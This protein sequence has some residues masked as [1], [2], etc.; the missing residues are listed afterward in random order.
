MSISSN[1]RQKFINMD[2]QLFL[3]YQL[4][5]LSLHPLNYFGI[6]I[7]NW[8]YMWG[9]ASTDLYTYPYANNTT[10]WSLKLYRNF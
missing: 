10:Y 5:R 1:V 8:L 6:F 3:H 2:I 9:S 4:K 7:K